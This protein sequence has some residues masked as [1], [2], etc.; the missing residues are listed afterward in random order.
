MPMTRRLAHRRPKHPL[1]IALVTALLLAAGAIALA[2][3]SQGSSTSK[4]SPSTVK[5]TVPLIQPNLPKPGQAVDWTDE[6][7]TDSLYTIAACSLLSPS[8]VNAAWT[9][10][11]LPALDPHLTAT[12]FGTYSSARMNLCGYDSHD[13]VPDGAV[14]RITNRAQYTLEIQCYGAGTLNVDD[15]YT[16]D[17]RYKADVQSF[18]NHSLTDFTGPTGLQYY[19]W[20]PSSFGTYQFAVVDRNGLSWIFRLQADAL[21]PRAVVQSLINKMII[22]LDHIVPVENYAKGVSK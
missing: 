17:L 11:G 14:T 6:N 3:S 4:P 16:R 21:T 5:R 22:N 19:N 12:R 15:C 20:G 13:A 18:E 8:E 7:Q 9:E 1:L 10:N 2:F